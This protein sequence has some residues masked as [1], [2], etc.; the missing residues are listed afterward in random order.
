[1]WRLVIGVFL[2]LHGLVHVGAASAPAPG[3]EDEGAFRFFMGED[4]SWLLRALGIGNNMSW[5]LAVVLIGLATA[6]FVIA[7]IAL[8]SGFGIWRGLAIGSAIMSL[9]LLGLYWNRYLPVGV[10]LNAGILVA[11]LWADWPQDETL[12]I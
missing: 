9:L 4:R 6:G 2:I 5:W 1:M 8:L 3:R 10:A 11:L 12:G 7:G